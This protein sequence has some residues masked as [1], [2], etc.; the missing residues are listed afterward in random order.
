MRSKMNIPKV[1]TDPAKALSASPISGR[2]LIGGKLVESS[3]GG[4]IDCLNPANEE[5]IG[6]VPRGT[7]NDVGRAVEFAEEAHVKWGAL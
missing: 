4:W 7:A 3:D 2:M 6:K 1:Q 5:Y